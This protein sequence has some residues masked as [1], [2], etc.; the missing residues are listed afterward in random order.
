MSV[1]TF[2][3]FL[4]ILLTIYGRSA[5][6]ACS[7]FPNPT[8]HKL[9]L[10]CFLSTLYYTIAVKMPWPPKE[11]YCLVHRQYNSFTSTCYWNVLFWLSAWKSQLPSMWKL[12]PLPLFTRRLFLLLTLGAHAQWGLQYLVCVSVCLF[13]CLSV[14]STSNIHSCHRRYLLHGGWRSEIL[15]GFFSENSPL[16]T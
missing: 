6:V 2:N 8:A 11:W 14:H 16:Q 3:Y 15:C 1:G 4:Y 12:W 10:C 9:L 5:F 7:C 13:V